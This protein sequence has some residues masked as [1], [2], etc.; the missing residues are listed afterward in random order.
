[1]MRAPVLHVQPAVRHLVSVPLHDRLTC[2]GA[3]HEGSVAAQAAIRELLDAPPLQHAPRVRVPLP[4]HP[5][6]HS[7]PAQPSEPHLLGS[8]VGGTE[9]DFSKGR[10]ESRATAAATG[11]DA[12]GAAT[13]SCG[14]LAC[15]YVCAMSHA[16][17]W[18]CTHARLRFAML[19]H[20]VHGVLHGVCW[21]HPSP[22]SKHKLH[23]CHRRL[24]EYSPPCCAVLPPPRQDLRIWDLCLGISSPL[25][26]CSAVQSCTVVWA[27]PRCPPQAGRSAPGPARPPPPLPGMQSAPC[28]EPARADMGAP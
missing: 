7:R 25:T 27:A 22:P 20:V 10:A 1:M 4:L 18:P 26:R 17:S 24:Q 16:H 5:L 11:S 13:D 8:L 2:V 12:T 19:R 9:Q 21:A 3:V 23:L 28:R 14:T 15:S 6:R